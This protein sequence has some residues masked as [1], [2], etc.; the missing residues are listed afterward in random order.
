MITKFQILFNRTRQAVITG[1]LVE[2]IVSF[3]VTM[4][5]ESLSNARLTDW[6]CCVGRWLNVNCQ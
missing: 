1:E 3:F 4:S 6:C 2:I 5:A